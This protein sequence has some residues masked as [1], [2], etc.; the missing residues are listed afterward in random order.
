M[1]IEG[2][3]QTK[4]H[5]YYMLFWSDP[6]QVFKYTLSNLIITADFRCWRHSKAQCFLKALLCK[7]IIAFSLKVFLR[8]E[9]LLFKIE[10]YWKQKVRQILLGGIE[11][12]WPAFTQKHCISRLHQVLYSWLPLREGRGSQKAIN[13]RYNYIWVFG[14]FYNAQHLLLH[15]QSTTSQQLLP[16][17]TPSQG[18]LFHF[19]FQKSEQT[20]LY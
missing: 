19:L 10:E 3:G 20:N 16:F 1:T 14:G 4:T 9:G 15:L 8:R 7:F 11:T 5:L 17:S 18:F 12:K 2:D 6:P 13:R